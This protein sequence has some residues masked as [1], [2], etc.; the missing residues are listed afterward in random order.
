MFSLN[1]SESWGSTV[2]GGTKKE[3]EGK[4]KKPEMISKSSNT[5]NAQINEVEFPKLRYLL[6]E[7]KDNKERTFLAPQGSFPLE[8]Y[9]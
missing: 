8:L 6:E 4:Q 3:N 9:L 7:H 2:L 5:G 1:P